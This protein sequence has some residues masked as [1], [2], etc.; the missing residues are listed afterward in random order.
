MDIITINDLEVQTII[1]A[2]DW[3]QHIRQKLRIT[4][5]FAVDIAAVANDDQL[6]ANT[7]Y[8]S[9]ASTITEFAEQSQTQLLETFANNVINLLQSKFHLSWLRLKIAKPGAVKN[10][11]D[12]VLTVER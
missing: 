6:D 8:A 9:I 12:I 3:E 10:A 4:L 7:D 2:Y 11:K 1:G 5:D